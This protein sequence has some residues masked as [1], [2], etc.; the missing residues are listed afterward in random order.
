MNFF[1]IC[2]D[3]RKF[4]SLVINVE[5]IAEIHDC[6]LFNFYFLMKTLGR[7]NLEW[8]KVFL[9]EFSISSVLN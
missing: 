9:T 2:K 4:E 7:M 1:K 8:R 6:E 5:L 3:G